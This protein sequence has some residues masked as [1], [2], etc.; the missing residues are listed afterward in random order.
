MLSGLERALSDVVSRI[1]RRLADRP[2]AAAIRLAV[3]RGGLVRVESLARRLGTGRRQLE[4]LYRDRVGIPPK[5]FLRILRFQRALGSIRDA[6]PGGWAQV[7]VALGFYDQSHLI[8]DFR[9]L[10]GRAPGEWSAHDASLAAVFSAVRRDAGG[11][12]DED[13]AFFQDAAAAGA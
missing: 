4:R 6:R 3:E 13:V 5:L 1:P 9:E 2:A 11:P 8:R 7:A 10:A 12:R